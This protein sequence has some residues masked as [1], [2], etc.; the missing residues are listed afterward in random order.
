MTEFCLRKSNQ[1]MIMREI[2]PVSLLCCPNQAAAFCQKR[3]ENGMKHF[4]PNLIIALRAARLL[5]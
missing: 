4:V 1:R 3:T 2:E 5:C